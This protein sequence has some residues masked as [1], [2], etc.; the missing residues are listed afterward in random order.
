[1]NRRLLSLAFLLF[2]VAL[3]LPL[4]AQVDPELLAGMKARSIGPAGMSGRIAAIEAVVSNPDIIYVGAATGGLWKSES[5]GLTWTPIFDDQPVNSIGAVAVFQPNPDIVWVGTGESN[6]RNSVSIGNGLYKSLDAGR[7]WRRLGLEETEHIYRILLHPTYPSVAYVCALGKV[8]GENAERG[9]FKT[10]D[11]G[12]TWKKVLYVDEKTGC[13]DLAMDPANPDH[14]IAAMWQFRRWPWFFK[15]GGPGSGLH[16]TFDG[17]KSWKK[18]GEDDGLPKGE[19]G[20]SGLAFSLSDPNIVYALVEAEKNVLL[21]SDD[22][23]LTWK[24]VNEQSN[25]APRPFYYADIRVDPARP[26]RVYNLHSMVTVS[27]DGGKSFRPL[28]SFSSVHPDHHAMWINPKN[29]AHILDG[30]DGGVAVSQDR[31]QTWRFVANLPLAQYYHIRVD[32]DKPYN[33]YGGMQ[34]NGSWRGPASVWENGGIRNHHWEEVG[35]GDGFDTAP[36]PA[37]SMMGYAMSQ[38]GYIS[39]WN[40]RTGERKDVRPP[41]PDGVELRF[42]WNAG[43]ALDPFEPG[44]IY[45]GSQ[46]LH[47]S[48]D[49]GDTWTIISPDLTT[50]NPEWQKSNESGGLTPDVSTAE[51]FTTIIAVAP[52]PVQRGVIWVGTDDGRLHVTRDAGQTWTSVE[53]NIKGVPANTWIPHLEPSRF[54]AGTAFVVFD[55]HRRSNFAPYVFKTANFGK[56]WTSL[57]TPEL[58]GYCL[59]IAQDPVKEDLLF[60]GTEFGLYVSLNGGKQWLPWKHGVPTA[61]VMDLVVHPREHD[62]VIATH[63]RAAYVL[64]DIRPL[65][66]LT[67]EAL[68]EPVHLFEIPDAQQYMVKQTGASRFPGHGEFRGENRPYGALLTYSLNVEGLPTPKEDEERR[69][70]EAST[71]AGRPS[72]EEADRRPQAEIKIT[73]A[74]G[75][76]IRTFKQRAVRGVNR[77]VWD[78][79]RDR[80]REPRREGPP[81]FFE[82]RYLEV[83]PGT[84]TVAVKYKE[85]EARGTLR[86]AAD[87]RYQTAPEDRQANWQTIERAGRLQER[88]TDAIERIR[89]TR[90]D[91]DVV[92]KKL[93]E[94]KKDPNA[95]DPPEV[96]EL[97]QS[98]KALKDALNALEKRLWRPPDAKGLTAPTDAWSKVSY[99]LRAVGS[100][101]DAPTPA[102]LDYLRQ[103]EALAEKALADND[104]LF[105]AKVA[106]FRQQVAAAGIALLPAETKP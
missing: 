93:A 45:Y 102:T 40:L 36:D 105:A 73:D 35:F 23:G 5:G 25:V 47:K 98:A 79:R 51:N 95:E 63:G 34:D 12:E 20:R 76:L 90:D 28:I 81:S 55:D 91:I 100:S 61:S 18:L 67:A 78:L 84:Y 32:M 46:F 101:W 10:V 96:K 56:D 14:L 26:D 27:D 54:D 50:N 21:R 19:L 44:T 30:N 83:L 13:G 7:T 41:A 17:G 6:P 15:S 59:A 97:R 1:M 86:V 89:S 77:A 88:L 2:V 22:G 24:K 85:Q 62:L 69:K 8:W 43:L 48:T 70:K 64:D 11:G 53:K 42:N 68:K 99:V 92:L 60:L 65:R 37:D 94:R 33:V 75:K 82:P 38:G 31:G 103:A 39:R 9:V 72:D 52:S 87:P 80:F 74:D 49:R 58:R 57:A 104:Q 29:A 71:G 106:D 66:A 3:A 4:A 16:Y